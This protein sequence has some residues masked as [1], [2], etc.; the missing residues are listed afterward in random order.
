MLFVL[1]YFIHLF[2]RGE[3]LGFNATTMH[4]QNPNYQPFQQHLRG[5]CSLTRN[6]CVGV[7]G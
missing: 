6:N 3:N 4:Q 7:V 1:N 5:K 2:G